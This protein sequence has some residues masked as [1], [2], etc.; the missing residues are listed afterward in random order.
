MAHKVEYFR[1]PASVVTAFMM[2]IAL[3]KRANKNKKSM[4]YPLVSFY[5]NLP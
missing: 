4:D 2:L 5:L 1:V 3:L